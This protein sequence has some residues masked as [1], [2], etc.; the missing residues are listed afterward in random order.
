MILF[1]WV[2]YYKKAIF[3]W[4]SN[5]TCDTLYIEWHCYN[6]NE[7]FYN[8]LF[9]QYISTI[10]NYRW[11]LSKYNKM[12]IFGKFLL[13]IMYHLYSALYIKCNSYAAYKMCDK[14]W[15]SVIVSSTIYVPGLSSYPIVKWLIKANVILEIM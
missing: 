10:Q 11:H 5:F 14:R 3:K 12:Q 4:K 2:S 1:W 15:L 7:W 6:K 13:L 8:V 9:H